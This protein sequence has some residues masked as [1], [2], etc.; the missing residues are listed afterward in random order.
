MS[1]ADKIFL[2]GNIYTLTAEGQKVSALAV[3]DGK[4][5][6]I[7]SDEEIKAIPA[8]ETVDLDGK[9]VLPG[10]INTHCHISD[11]AEN[12]RKINLEKA[13]SI[14]NVI[15][16][17]KEGLKHTAPGDWLNGFQL[18]LLTLDERRLPDR[19]ELDRVSTEVP[20]FISSICKHNFIVNSKALELAG[21]NRSFL[22]TPEGEFAEFD[23]SGEPTGRLKEHGLLKYFNAV[24]PPL[25]GNRQTKL[26][27][28]EESLLNYAAQGF[29]TVHSFNGF[30]HSDLEQPKF[31]QE[32]DAQGRL[33]V[34]VILNNQLGTH[35]PDDI[36]SGFGSDKVKYGAVKFFAD[37]S[38]IQWSAYLKENYS[39]REGYRG[40]LIHDE[41]ELYEGIKRAYEDGND[42]AV[43]VIGDGAVEAVL[44]I[45]ERIYDPSKKQRFRLIHCTLTAPEQWERIAKYAVIIDTQP[46]FMPIVGPLGELRLGAERAKHMLTI[47]SWLDRGIIVT[48]SDDSPICDNNPFVGIRFAVLRETAFDGEIVSP[49]ERIS[50]Y[51]AVKLYTVNAAYSSREQH[52]KGTVEEGKYADLIVLDR[53]IFNIPPKEISEIKVLE[54]YLGGNAVLGH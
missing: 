35:R 4:I 22:G 7:G 50:V 1:I 27:V 42:I 47:K 16:L 14:Q 44:D 3:Y 26:D 31:Y 29:T 2:N 21:I 38:L 5:V 18:N 45:I 25:L 11:F 30:S 32:L 53:D 28:L 41:Q 49:W 51:D 13:T 6:A 17:L 12:S 36:I 33:P 20:V 54:N 19:W 40:I 39:D 34:R 52:V 8:K 43:H 46:I 24:M 10:F 48:G 9:T 23:Q 15:D 37:G